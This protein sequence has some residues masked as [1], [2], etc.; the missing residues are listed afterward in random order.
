MVFCV[1]LVFLDRAVRFRSYLLF[2]PNSDHSVY[3]HALP[4]EKGAFD[5]GCAFFRS[6]YD[7]RI[8]SATA[9]W[10]KSSELTCFCWDPAYLFERFGHREVMPKSLKDWDWVSMVVFLVDLMPPNIE[11]KTASGL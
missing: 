9:H 3:S 1:T 10:D 7:A 5:C 4:S 6:R 11:D 2:W 8:H